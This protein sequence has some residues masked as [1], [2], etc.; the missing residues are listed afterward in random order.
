MLTSVLHPFHA[1][2]RRGARCRAARSI[3]TPRTLVARAQCLAGASAKALRLKQPCALI[4]DGV[5][6]DLLDEMAVW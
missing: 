2:R 4:V 6:D 5:D 3:A 1:G